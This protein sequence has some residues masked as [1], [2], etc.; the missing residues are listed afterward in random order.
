MRKRSA[1]RA[2]AL[3]PARRAGGPWRRGKPR[4][5]SPLSCPHQVQALEQEGGNH[6]AGPF[7]PPNPVMH[8]DDRS[9][10][11]VVNGLAVTAKRKRN[12]NQIKAG[13][14]HRIIRRFNELNATVK[15]I[16]VQNG[17]CFLDV[18][19]ARVD[20]HEPSFRQKPLQDQG[21]PRKKAAPDNRHPPW[22]ELSRQEASKGL[23]VRP[24]QVPLNHLP[25]KGY[26]LKG[27]QGEELQPPEDRGP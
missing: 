26:S 6:H 20:D 3:L 9:C 10:G 25:A 1:S 5:G 23:L 8:Q 15:G 2:T 16:A 12:H 7:R 19:G 11:T 17:L 24:D 14:L 21:G 27:L 22:L 18:L 4:G 13:M